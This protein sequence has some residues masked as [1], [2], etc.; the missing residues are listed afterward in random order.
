[1]SHPAPPHHR[2]PGLLQSGALWLQG[3]HM[4]VG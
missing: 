4:A 3:A 1:M 2:A